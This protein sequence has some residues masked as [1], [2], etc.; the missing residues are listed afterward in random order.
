[1]EAFPAKP[2]RSR[3][4][5]LRMNPL[6]WYHDVLSLISSLE[7]YNRAFAMSRVI[8]IK[9]DVEASSRLEK[10]EKHMVFW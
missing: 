10:A 8:V 1:M 5:L 7:S 9:D 3:T 6:P 4:R 2:S